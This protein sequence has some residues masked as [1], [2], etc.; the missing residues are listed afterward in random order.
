MGKQQT[1]VL[2]ILLAALAIITLVACGGDDDQAQPASVDAARPQPE[3]SVETEHKQAANEGAER[4]EA[5]ESAA[6]R[7]TAATADPRSYASCV[8]CHGPNGGGNRAMNA[9]SLVNQDPWYIKRQLQHFKSGLR[10]AARGDVYG[11]QMAAFA[12]MLA[13][14]AAIDS[15]VAYID[16]FPD[17]TPKATIKGDIKR[18]AD[19]YSNVCGACHGPNAEGNEILQAPALAGVDDWYLLRQLQ[20]FAGGKRGADEADKYGYQMAMMMQSLPDEQTMKDVVSYIQSL[21]E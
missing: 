15:V 3:R 14:E 8:S 17:R 9:P 7:T 4:T 6:P 2:K 16:G 18:G 21:A 19:F 12:N 11:M 1:Q 13:D 10:G 20:N 5:A